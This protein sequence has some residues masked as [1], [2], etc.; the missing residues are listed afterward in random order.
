MVAEYALAFFFIIVEVRVV[1]EYALVVIT[2][3]LV[4]V[5]FMLG[6]AFLCHFYKWGQYPPKHCSFC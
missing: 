3:V 2:K 1:A 5:C 4:L 6:P